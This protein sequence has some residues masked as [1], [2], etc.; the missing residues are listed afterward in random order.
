MDS[1]QDLLAAIGADDVRPHAVAVKLYEYWQQ[2]EGKEAKE[3]KEEE[4]PLVL[5]TTTAKPKAAHLQVAGVNGLL[6][7]L[8]NCCCPLPGDEIVGFISR[9]KGVIV[10]RADCHNVQRYQK[11]DRERLIDVNWVSMNQPRYMAPIAIIARDRSGLIRDIAAVISE[12]GINMTSVN[13]YVN[14]NRE[15]VLINVTVEVESLDQLTRLF[16]RLE[17]V[18]NILKVERDLGKGSKP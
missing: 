4:E 10:H 15:T 16:A 18:K 17:R 8:A 11:R 3:S 7:K 12:A 14:R 13:S 6:T 5:P 9:G 1:F 2:R